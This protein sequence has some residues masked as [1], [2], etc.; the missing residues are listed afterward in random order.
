[1]LL[2]FTAG[3]GLPMTDGSNHVEKLVPVLLFIILGILRAM[4]WNLAN[5]VPLTY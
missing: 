5:N 3:W 2:A 4:T 1:M